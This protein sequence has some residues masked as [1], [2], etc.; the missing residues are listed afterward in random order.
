M[1][2]Q[3]KKEE[4]QGKKKEKQKEKQKKKKES[5]DTK[6]AGSFCKRQYNASWQ[7]IKESRQ[8]I[9]AVIIVFAVFAIIGL[10]FPAP[11]ELIEKIQEI[12]KELLEAIEGKS[13]IGLISYI[14]VNNLGVSFFSLAFGVF[15]GIIPAINA[16]VN[17]YFLG[18]V[19]GVVIGEVGFG[20][21]WR[22]LPHGIFELPAV[23]ISLGLGLRLGFFMLAAKPGEEFK[24]RAWESGRVFLFV[25]VPLLLIAAIIEGV[26]IGLTAAG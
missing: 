2:K 17:G 22:L 24:R 14:F 13:T 4:K 6:D 10:I 8:S 11:P 9:Y 7:Y 12:V 18:F 26:L 23:F 1:K 20:E 19:G 25:V 21:L 3:K 15:F 16:A 5:R